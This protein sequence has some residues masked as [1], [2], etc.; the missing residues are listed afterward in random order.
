M[1]C[2]VVSTGL[3]HA[4]TLS[5]MA[6]EW[7]SPVWKRIG[8]ACGVLT[9]MVA[10]AVLAGMSPADASKHKQ[11]AELQV[12]SLTANRASI[13]PGSSL[14]LTDTVVNRGRKKAP[15]SHTGYLLSSTETLQTDGVIVRLL[16][17][18]TLPALKP[19]KKSR[20]AKLVNVPKPTSAGHYFVFACADVVNGIREENDRNNCTASPDPIEIVRQGEPVP[21]SLTPE[22]MDFGL[23]EVGSDS[24]LAVVV[25]R[26]E[27]VAPARR[28]YF[29]SEGDR[30]DFAD[31][32]DD[33]ANRLAPGAS[34]ELFVSFAPKSV[35]EKAMTLVAHTV[36]GG[37]DSATLRG[38]GYVTR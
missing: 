27:G 33:C 22:D 10:L 18:R 35:G 20:G 24:E 11:R 26:N 28:L 36:S 12:R 25:V 30:D 15:A 23:V 32:G 21:I 9:A 14:R 3:R 19:G 1:I 34:C 5:P 13:E 4:G 2:P 38:T 31:G 37:Q 6:R 17:R 29:T 8:L 16:G 7:R